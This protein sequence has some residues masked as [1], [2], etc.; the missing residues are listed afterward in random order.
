MFTY[1]SLLLIQVFP[2]FSSNI[3]NCML[4]K[5]KTKKELKNILTPCWAPHGTRRKMTEYPVLALQEKHL[6]KHLVL[7]GMT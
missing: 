1:N 7:T 6:V 2:R 4:L 5:N 3:D